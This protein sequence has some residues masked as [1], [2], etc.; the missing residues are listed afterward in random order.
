MK[1]SKA[2]ASPVALIYLRVSSQAQ[3][4]SGAGIDGQLARCQAHAAKLGLEVAGTFKDEALSGGDGVADRPGLAALIA[5]SKANP[6]AITIVY[7]VSRLARSQL[8]L[9]RL[10]DDRE[11]G[12][13][14]SIS[15]ASEPFDCT[16]ATG[17]AFLGMVAIFSQLELEMA[18]ERTK[19]A[20][21]AVKARGVKLGAKS[22]TERDPELV[23][24]V[25][26]M[27]ATTDDKGKRVFSHKSLAE[28]LNRLGIPAV[29]GGKW[30]SKT[31]QALLVQAKKLPNE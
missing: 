24:K 1:K 20:L 8:L 3:K 5:A 30:W 15:S 11:D 25:G 28:E 18:G 14:L 21:A 2:A 12:F 19:V 22:M 31:V 13:G 27:Y 16:T 7:S 26:D 10:V 29:R 4:D 9:W 6:G 23:R 17:R